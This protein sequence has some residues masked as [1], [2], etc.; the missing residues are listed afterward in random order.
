MTRAVLA[1]VAALGVSLSGCAGAAVGGAPGAPAAG[2]GGASLRREDRV[3]VSTYDEVLGVAASR[4]LVFVLA[5]RGLGIYDRTFD[6]WRPPLAAG[7]DLPQGRPTALAADP[8]SDAVWVG[9]VGSVTYYQPLTDYATRSSVPGVVDLI[10]F[11]RGNPGD[12][13]VRASGQ[14][15]RVSSTGFVT[16]LGPGQLPLASALEIPETLRDI[17]REFPSLESFAPL[18]TRD[19]QLRSWPVSAAAKSPDRASELWLGTLGN[20]LYRVDPSFNQSRHLPFGLLDPGAGALALA[21]DGVWVA[22]LGEGVGGGARGGLTFASDDLQRW[23]WLE[24]PRSTPLVGARAYDL[25]VRGDVAWIATD[26][27][28]AR[29]ATRSGGGDAGEVGD[30][31]VL[32]AIDGLPSDAA[33]AVAARPGGA[34]VGTPRGVVYVADQASDGRRGARPRVGPVLASGAAVR[35]LL[36]TGDTLWVGSDFGLLLVP[37]GDSARVVRATA[38]GSDARLG[39]RIV[40]LA[41]SDTEVAVATP[42]AVL[43]IHRPT[44]R[45][46]PPIEGAALASLGGIRALAMDA[47][48]LWAAG[49]RGVVV[50]RRAGGAP[51]FLAV[52]GDL[53]A[54]AFDVALGSDYAWVATRDGVVRLRRLRD[55]S[56]P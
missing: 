33:L 31:V 3:V 8:T 39:R 46:L 6:A 43:R 12:A 23:R 38:Q 17:A 26:R 5:P 22:A 37:P 14:W 42:D 20:G 16:P 52:P 34:W 45:A 10:A 44:G 4:R 27:G 28:L 11:D 32:T 36:A 19:A 30:F 18:L 48:T 49:P 29:V 54:E 56:V 35:A 2:V 50:L 40:A 9:G 15:S 55:G 25:D 24:P 53:P 21:A 51:R 13:Y 47:R 1:A 41:A 7:A